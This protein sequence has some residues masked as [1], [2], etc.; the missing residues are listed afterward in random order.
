[1]GVRML[2]PRTTETFTV[3]YQAGVAEND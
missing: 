2:M 3:W 1:M